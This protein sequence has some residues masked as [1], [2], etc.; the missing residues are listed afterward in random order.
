MIIIEGL[1]ANT[2]C[3]SRVQGEKFLFVCRDFEFFFYYYF[4]LYVLVI[5]IDF[6]LFHVEF[7]DVGQSLLYRSAT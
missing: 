1:Y 2:P 4:S 7:I 3:K 5:E 6:E